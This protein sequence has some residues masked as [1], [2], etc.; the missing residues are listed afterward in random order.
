MRSPNKSPDSASGLTTAEQPKQQVPTNAKSLVLTAE[1]QEMLQ[2]ASKKR[3]T[4]GISKSQ[5]FD[6][7]KNRLRKPSMLSKSYSHSA[8]RGS[9]D[10]LPQDRV[11]SGLP[12]V[13][14]GDEKGNALIA[15]DRTDVL[16]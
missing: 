1:D 8:T 4:P 3:G 5:G 2:C 13:D 11:S 10:L 6:P 15:M 12:V 16:R 9:K 7:G 14:S